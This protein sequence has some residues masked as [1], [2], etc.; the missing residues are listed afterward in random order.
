MATKKLAVLALASAFALTAAI[1][2]SARDR[3]DKGPR[4]SHR[5]PSAAA[6][7]SAERPN[8]TVSG[9]GDP[10]RLRFHQQRSSN[11]QPGFL[12]KAQCTFTCGDW[13]ITCSG[14]SASCED[15]SGCTA[16]GGGSTIEV[17]CL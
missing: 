5:V 1:P 2:A 10:K 4:E 8:V 6:Q 17:I 15:E 9:H 14:S 3:E 11:G 16:S 12:E 7:R 13:E